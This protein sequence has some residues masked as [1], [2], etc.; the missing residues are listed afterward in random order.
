MNDRMG[1]DAEADLWF[2]ATVKYSRSGTNEVRWIEVLAL[3][4]WGKRQEALAA[5]PRSDQ[6]SGAATECPR[7][8]GAARR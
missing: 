1:W 8:A 7:I 2:D 4:A 5:L 3:N 6:G